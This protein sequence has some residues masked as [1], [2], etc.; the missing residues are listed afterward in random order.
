MSR[1]AD[2]AITD[3]SIVR[4]MRDNRSA[5][6]AEEGFYSAEAAAEW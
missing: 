6:P 4:L 5:I 2:N 3:G 1:F